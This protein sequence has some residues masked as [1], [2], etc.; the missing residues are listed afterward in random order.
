MNRAEMR[1][2]QREAAKA[3]KMYNLNAAQIKGLKNDATNMA[4]N[5][6]FT[7]MLAIPVM[8]LHDKYGQ[9]TR[10]EIDGKSREERFA[11]MCLDL[12]DSYEQGY[13]TFEDLKTCLEEETGMKLKE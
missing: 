6:A 3:S 7:L 12:Y 8:V 9:L 5:K 1:R 13:V 11:E 4:V 2:Q 10:K